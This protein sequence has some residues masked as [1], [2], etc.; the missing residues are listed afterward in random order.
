M[1]TKVKAHAVDGGVRS[2]LNA[3]ADAEANAARL[4]AAGA[5]PVD[6]TLAGEENVRLRLPN[7]RGP[8]CGAVVIGSIRRALL[9]R[10][11]KDALRRLSALPHQGRIA[12]QCGTRLLQAFQAVRRGAGATPWAA[13]FL[14]GGRD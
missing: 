10:A 12:A 13:G 14:F 2:V 7:R 9:R 5:P 3:V 11:D 1:L 4:V 6:W 8:G